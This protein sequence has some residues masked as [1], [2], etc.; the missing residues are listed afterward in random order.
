MKKTLL[1]TYT[2]RDNS[3]TKKLVDYFVQQS[4]EKTELDILDLNT[5][6]PDIWTSINLNPAL[7]RNF[8]GMD[9]SDDEKALL[10]KNDEAIDRLLAADYVVIAY[11]MFNFSMP[12]AVKVWI[13][14]IIQAGKTFS[15]GPE[16][17]KGLCTGKTALTI[18]TTGGEK[19]SLGQANLATPLINACM[20]LIGI[21]NNNITAYGFNENPDGVEQELERA[22]K[23]IDDK[24]TEMY[25]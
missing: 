9:I 16:G 5:D 11:P 2:P 23:E 3:N 1:V 4:A 14:A 8:M 6:M 25:L 24:I 17:Y 18:M 7:K 15:M 19:E 12:A 22:K 21:E 10:A 13:D 20:G